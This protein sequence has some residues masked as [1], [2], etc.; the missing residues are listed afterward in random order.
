MEYI[1][2][3][4]VQQFVLQQESSPSFTKTQ[5]ALQQE[6]SPPLTKNQRR[7]QLRHTL[8]NKITPQLGCFDNDEEHVIL[9]K[10]RRRSSSVSSKASSNHSHYASS[11]EDFEGFENRYSEYAED[12]S[13]PSSPVEDMFPDTSTVS[14]SSVRK[15]GGRKAS[16]YSEASTLV[17]DGF[18][19]L[20][21]LSQSQSR[22]VGPR[23][24]D[25]GSG[26]DHSIPKRDRNGTVSSTGSNKRDR[27]S[28]V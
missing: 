15:I 19:D 6:P 1:S 7:L 21:V 12:I 16:F 5:F 9:E 8:S 10:R 22:I 26:S 11:I 2:P 18:G 27:K 17:N 20:M 3:L 13:K 25:S 4:P 24:Y 14:F 28:V 23:F